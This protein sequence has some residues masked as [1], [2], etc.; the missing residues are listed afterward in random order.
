MT[1]SPLAHSKSGC[2]R[3]RRLDTHEQLEYYIKDFDWHET[4]V[5]VSLRLFL[6]KPSHRLVN[7]VVLGRINS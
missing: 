4:P 6:C 2:A 1:T 3:Q 5:I 7:V